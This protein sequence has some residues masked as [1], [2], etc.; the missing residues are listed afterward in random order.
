MLSKQVALE[1][2]M[3]QNVKLHQMMVADVARSTGPEVAEVERAEFEFPEVKLR[4]HFRLIEP[5]VAEVRFVDAVVRFVVVV[6]PMVAPVAMKQ[7]N[8]PVF[9]LVLE[10]EEVILC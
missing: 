10:T 7:M 9:V 2:L 4:A 8:V 1:V 6:A 3:E 5:L